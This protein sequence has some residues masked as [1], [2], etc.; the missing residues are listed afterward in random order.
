MKIQ[1]GPLRE[2]SNDDFVMRFVVASPRNE[3]KISFIFIYAT[4]EYLIQNLD[5]S[6]DFSGQDKRKIVDFFEQEVEE[7]KSKIGYK[8]FERR[9]HY[10][11]CG[12]ISEREVKKNIEKEYFLQEIQDLRIYK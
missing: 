8:I 2:L 7:W 3:I 11:I 4:R 9:K 5:V 10:C 12:N 6:E 1:K